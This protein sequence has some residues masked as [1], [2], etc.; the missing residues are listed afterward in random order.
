MEVSVV[1][2]GGVGLNIPTCYRCPER[3]KDGVRCPILQAKLDGVRGL[4]LSSFKF[5]CEKR[6]S[7]FTPGD[8]VDFD[9][10]KTI[11]DEFDFL[12]CTGIVMRMYPTKALIYVSESEYDAVNVP[13]MRLRH[14]GL[15]KT[16]KRHPVCIHCGRPEGAEIKLS[17]Q[18]SPAYPKGLH[19]W[20]C[21]RWENGRYQPCEYRLVEGGE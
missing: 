10:G 15:R 20:E 8:E 16:G 18:G 2:A 11:D 17:N 14:D 6:L 12:A 19:D 4:S 9:I 13:V 3:A 21:N 1:G 7:L 5:K